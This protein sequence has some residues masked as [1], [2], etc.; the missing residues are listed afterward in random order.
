MR[1]EWTRPAI[2]DLKSAGDYV[3][4]D[5]PRA[6]KH[7]ANHPNIGRPGRVV[8]TRELVI[9]RTPFLAFKIP[10]CSARGIALG[11]II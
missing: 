6:A 8:Q 1:L 7:M 2:N 9:S 11:D 4:E 3:A 5:S 10:V